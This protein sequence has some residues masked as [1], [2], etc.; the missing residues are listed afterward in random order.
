[1][2]LLPVN[3]EREPTAPRG[4]SRRGFLVAS[5]AAVPASWA[6]GTGGLARA[7][8]DG[9]SSTAQ[10]L[11]LSWYDTTRA[12]I[13]AAAFAEPVTQSRTW[14]VSWLAAAQAVGESTDPVFQSAAFAQA[15]HDTLVS[16]VPGQQAALDAAL[17][18][19]LASLPAGAAR[20][21]GTTAGA[22]TAATLLAARA[23]DGL[24][25][26]SVDIAWTPPA[27]SPGV[28]QLTP[29]VTRAAVRA[30]Q[31]SARSFLLAK[32]DQFDPGPPPSLTSQEYKDALTEVEN[33]G[34]ASSPRTAEQTD[35][36]LFWY[37]SLNFAYV[38]VLRAVLAASPYALAWQARFVAAFNV[39]TTDAQIAVYNAKYKYLFWRPYTAI[40]AGGFAQDP[41]WTSQSVAPQHPEY[42]SGHG[43][44]AGSADAVLAAFLGPKAPAP[45]PLTSPN[46]PGVTRTYADWQTITREIVDARVWEGVH[47]R[48]SDDT[49]VLQ[50]AEVA[51][52][53]LSKLGSLGI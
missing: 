10:A 45:I 9:G 3:S 17:A 8:A 12:A 23:G 30:G 50:G 18:D 40:T 39:I 31:G 38:Q 44:V 37:P 47:L 27:A 52:Y 35:I 6:L 51:A 34:G 26:A 1:M 22:G 14:A 5:A 36:A 41:S 43:A 32:N 42:P 16:Y 2:P 33:T 25:T 48:T 46:D 15:L 11:G 4:I 24:D 19:T 21:A 20:Q 28:F 29:P 49:G 7:A 53:E 13:T